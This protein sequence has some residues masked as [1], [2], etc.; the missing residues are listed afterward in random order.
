MTQIP[1]DIF[2]PDLNSN[3]KRNMAESS[4]APRRSERTRK[5]RN[6]DPDIIDSQAI[7]FLIEGDNENNVVNKIPVLL[8]VEDASKTYKEAITSRN[9][10]F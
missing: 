3:N 8:D 5:E 4:N 7:I 1:Q 6:L 10:S 9:S 2:G